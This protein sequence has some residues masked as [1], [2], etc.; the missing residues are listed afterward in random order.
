MEELDHKIKIVSIDG[1]PSPKKKHKSYKEG[2]VT[3]RDLVSPS[4]IKK[5]RRKKKE[6]I[7]VKAK[8]P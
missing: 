5:R 8:I 7:N 3:V 6:D 2:F 4:R 1:N